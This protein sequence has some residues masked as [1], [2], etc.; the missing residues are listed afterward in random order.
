MGDLAAVSTWSSPEE[1]FEAELRMAGHV[2]KEKVVHLNPTA[3]IRCTSKACRKEFEKAVKDLDYLTSFCLGRVEVRLSAPRLATSDSQ[4]PPY[5]KYQIRESEQRNRVQNWMVQQSPHG[6]SACGLK[7]KVITKQSDMDIETMCTIGGLIRVNDKIYGLTTGHGILAPSRPQSASPPRAPVS[8]TS[9]DYTLSDAE[10]DSSDDSYASS[11]EESSRI[12]WTSQRPLDTVTIG[13]GNRVQ[14]LEWRNTYSGGPA[15]FCE[16]SQGLGIIENISSNSD[17]ALVVMGFS[18]TFHLFNEY[19]ETSSLKMSSVDRIK[20][21]TDLISGHVSLL[22]GKDQTISGHLLEGSTTFRNQ[23]ATFCTRKIEISAPLLNPAKGVSGSWVIQDNYLCGVVIAVY[24][25]EPY[26]HMI[27][28]D[29]MFQDIRDALKCKDIAVATKNDISQSY[30]K[31]DTYTTSAPLTAAPSL[32]QEK[33]VT[34]DLE[35]NYGVSQDDSS[36]SYLRDPLLE[37]MDKGINLRDTLLHGSKELPSRPKWT[38]ANLIAV[39]MSLCSTILS[40][41]F[42]VL[43]SRQRSVKEDNQ[44]KPSPIF[45]TVLIV[46]LAEL[47]YTTSCIAAIGQ[48]LSHRAF[49]RRKFK[50]RGVSLAELEVWRIVVQPSL[51]LSQRW[52]MNLLFS[53]RSIIGV[54]SMITSLLAILY[55]PAAASIVWPGQLKLHESKWDHKSFTGLVQTDFADL[56]YITNNCVPRIGTGNDVSCFQNEA[57]SNSLPYLLESDSPPLRLDNLPP[58][59]RGKHTPGLVFYENT[60]IIGQWVDVVNGSAVSEI[61]HRTIDNVSLA[62][63]HPGVLVAS[64]F[65][66]ASARFGVSD[67]MTEFSLRASVPSLVTNVL[68]ASLNESDL[69]PVGSENE[70]RNAVRGLTPQNN[71]ALQEIFNWKSSERHLRVHPVFTRLP[72]SFSTVIDN[73]EENVQ[74]EVIYVLGNFGLTSKTDL[75]DSLVLCKMQGSVV[76]HCSS[77]FNISGSMNSLQAHCQDTTDNEAYIKVHPEAL[78]RAVPRWADVALEWA[79]SLS[80]DS[81][82]SEDVRLSIARRIMHMSLKPDHAEVNGKDQTLAEVL[83]QMSAWT[84]MKSMLNAPFELSQNSSEA[85]FTEPETQVFNAVLR[86]VGYAPGQRHYSQWYHVAIVFCVLLQS[87]AITVYLLLH[88]GSGFKTDVSE[89]SNLFALAMNA[90][91]NV[92]KEGCG[93]SGFRKDQFKLTCSINKK[94]GYPHWVPSQEKDRYEDDVVEERQTKLVWRGYKGPLRQRYTPLASEM[95]LEQSSEYHEL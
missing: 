19:R 88:F 78:V 77:H 30:D 51:L 8:S 72:K 7:L 59:N 18:P 92:L 53:A 13:A 89:P 65:K 94:G 80:L 5:R 26:V 62:M 57:Y 70:P 2:T 55:G 93:A 60:T 56:N 85:T 45:S 21:D 32:A 20:H 71:T 69:I 22:I 82:G 38:W 37:T 87:L 24:E 81:G 36:S 66:N 74:R 14:Q 73:V 42:V 27:T 17:F 16:K 46:K 48:V 39:A 11:D 23:T 25:T 9:S 90:P 61:Y 83:A 68:C 3:C 31:T 35:D 49:D 4:S 54:I 79:R 34:N 50:H 43:S 84:L 10:S 63:P 44:T 15:C 91:P 33:S 12:E 6:G 41:I 64:P 75:L 47:A 1:I 76:P 52:V 58:Q 28:T 29:K 67:V 86:T 40:S 95:P